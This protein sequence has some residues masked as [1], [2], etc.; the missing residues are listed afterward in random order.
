[1]SCKDGEGGRIVLVLLA[2]G[3]CLRL[4]G[5][6]VGVPITSLEF[7]SREDFES[8]ASCP[9]TICGHIG[10]RWIRS[11][12]ERTGLGRRLGYLGGAVASIAIMELAGVFTFLPGPWNFGLAV[13]IVVI[14]VICAERV[15]YLDFVPAWFVGSGMFFAVMGLGSASSYGEGVSQL[16]FSCFIGMI[17]GYVTVWGRG[18]Y[19]ATLPKT[20]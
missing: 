14:P 13:F 7:E 6:V 8:R 15:P 3:G 4:H 10:D 18:K 12:P 19:E 2:Q 5:A 11:F 17:F 16:M 1:M 20:E 9:S